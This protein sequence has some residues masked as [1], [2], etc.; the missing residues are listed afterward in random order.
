MS[1]QLVFVHGRSQQKKDASTLKAEWVEALQDGLAKNGLTLPIGDASI[2]FPFYGDTLYELLQGASLEAAAEVVVRG[3]NAEDE[4][5]RFARAIMEE[6]RRKANITEADLVDVAGQQVVNRGVLNWEW[7]QAFL[8]VVDRRVPFGSGCSIALFTHDVYVYLNNP[9]VR[10]KIDA[11]VSEAI[12]PDA[13]TVVVAHS[14]GTVV[15]YNILRQLAQA[16]DWKIPLFVTLGSPLAVAE[17]RKTVRSLATGR[18]PERVS[19]WFNALDERDVVALYPL[20][21]MNFPV[22][23]AV[24]GIENKRDVKN[25]TENH[26]GISGYLDDAEVAQRIHKALTT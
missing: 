14:L 15:A 13:E 11:G 16:R 23:P 1:R 22:D 18:C 8:Q 26:H 12:T 20:D 2:H 9:I 19:E 25:K 10:S 17:I 7:F 21:P 6:I 3:T 5:K 24:P 4:E